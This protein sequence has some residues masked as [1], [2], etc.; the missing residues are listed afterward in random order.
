MGWKSGMLKPFSKVIAKKVRAQAAMPVQAQ[1]ETFEFLVEKGKQTLF[2][3][4][5]GFTTIIH[6]SDFCRQV[7]LTE[8]EPFKPYIKKIMAG[9]HDVLWPGKPKYLAKTSGTTS[10]TKY[11]PISRESIQHHLD[12][13]RNS[14]MLYV[15]ESNDFSVFDGKM[16]FVSGSPELEKTGNVQTGRLSGIVNHHVPFYAKG[17]QLPSY[18]TNCIEDWET[19]IEK[20][21]DETLQA[22]LRLI[23]GIPPWV[24]MFYEHIIDRTG[25]SIIE[26]FPNFNVFCH[27]GVNFEPY[28][29]KL[30]S[31]VGKKIPI[32]E[33]YPAS[34]GFIA[35]TDSQNEEGLLLNLDGGIF[36]EFVPVNEVYL[37]NATRLQ[38]KDVE[39]GTNY[40]V[41]IN[42]DAGLWGYII[43]DTVKFV[44]KNPYRLIVTG[45]IKHYISAFG[46]HVITE[47]VEG[48]ILNLASQND[49][50]I[51]EFTV[52]PQVNP[53][54]GGTPYHEW[55]VE[56]NKTPEK[57]MQFIA[58]LD[59]SLQK[60]NIYY[61]DL[62]TGS[63]LRPLKLNLMKRNAFRDYM[64]SKG[65]LGGQNKVPRLANDRLLAD[66][67]LPYIDQSYQADD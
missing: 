60:K 49:L 31:A 35:Y 40:A 19:K 15:V 3:K 16:I 48:S 56:F 51:I 46:E 13:A 67:L 44:S 5:H 20:I 30:E 54:G 41:V 26:V 66:E 62:I 7:P 34:E 11:I 4:E 28:R 9:Q 14:L 47:E 61:R 38:L 39:L 43:G 37:N 23:G 29:A 65:K 45:R 22:D 6:H 8:Y 18:E 1:Q 21:V 24:L 64:K 58:D 10:G 36:Y 53:P 2:G 33:T 25:K 27:G 59:R 57:P 17:N 52:A 50:E 12:A 55:F 63:V 32:I 42:S